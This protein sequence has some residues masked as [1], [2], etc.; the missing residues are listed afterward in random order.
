VGC[1][2][3]ATYKMA[4]GESARCKMRGAKPALCLVHWP[5]GILEW[6]SV[7]QNLVDMIP[8]SEFHNMATNIYTTP[9]KL[10]R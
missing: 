10:K 6:S 8:C 9:M 1:G 4:C 3:W 2:V 5:F 7:A